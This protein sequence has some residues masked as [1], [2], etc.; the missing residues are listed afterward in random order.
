MSGKGLRVRQQQGK[1]TLLDFG[2]L[3]EPHIVYALQ[4]ILMPKECFSVRTGHIAEMG[5][6]TVR[7]PQTFLRYKEGNLDP[8]ADLQG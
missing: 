4:Q 2:R 7:V 5:A 8:L 1:G 3:R 6:L